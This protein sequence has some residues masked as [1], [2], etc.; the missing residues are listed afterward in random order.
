MTHGNDQDAYTIVDAKF[1]GI[2]PLK[3]RKRNSNHPTL[4]ISTAATNTVSPP[5]KTNQTKLVTVPSHVAYSEYRAELIKDRKKRSAADQD[6]TVRKVDNS[7]LNRRK[8]SLYTMKKDNPKEVL[9]DLLAREY[10]KTIAQSIGDKKKRMK[11]T[12]ETSKR[13]SSID[14]FLDNPEMLDF[15]MGKLRGESK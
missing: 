2:D 11:N 10:F 7:I 9:D 6:P 3:R 4:A 13:S 15:M 12:P 1:E 5:D 14:A 8:K